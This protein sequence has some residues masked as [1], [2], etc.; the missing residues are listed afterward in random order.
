MA[1]A[2]KRLKTT[3]ATTAKVGTLNDIDSLIPDKSYLD[4]YVSRQVAGVEDFT[5]FDAARRNKW[6]TL[7]EGPT[8]SGKTLF[9]MAAAARAGL[10][11]FSVTAHAGRTLESMVGQRVQNDKGLWVW[12]Y[13]PVATLVMHG[14]VLLF[15][16]ANFLPERIT[17]GLFSLLDAR[18]TLELPD[19]DGEVITAHPDL[20]ILADMNPHYQGTRELN[21]AFR[22]RFAQK[23]VW[24]YDPEVEKR[25]VK[26]STLLGVAADIRRRPDDVESPTSTNMLMVF[27]QM[28]KEFGL[29]YAIL[30][31]LTAYDDAERSSVK[32]VIEL[33]RQK[34]EDD[35]ATMEAPPEN[36]DEWAWD[37]F[38]V[39]ADDS[40]VRV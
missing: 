13:G 4:T 33:N 16:E 14:G 39:P 22:N 6:N 38:P 20:V 26:S 21:Y 17:S 2:M 31:F 37:L 5:L 3:P 8:G 9:C 12:Q 24:D 28:Y 29:D 1:A 18:R 36:D 19:N 40:K 34:I 25:L 15:N 11:F 7:I 30:N 23:I 35:L 27:E 32:N 10:P